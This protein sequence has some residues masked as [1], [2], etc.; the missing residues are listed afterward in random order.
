MLKARL[1]ARRGA[2]RRDGSWTDL[3]TPLW[4][5]V[6]GDKWGCF[7]ERM[8]IIHSC[9]VL[10]VLSPESA[11]AHENPVAR[12]SCEKRLVESSSSTRCFLI[13]LEEKEP[14]SSDMIIPEARSYGGEASHRS[15]SSTC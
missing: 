8:Y 7:E 11:D 12:E 15:S 13:S 2:R 3:A 10:S 6:S 9:P 5:G 1:G 14:I 4:V